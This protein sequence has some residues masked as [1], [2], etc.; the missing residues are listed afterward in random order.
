MVKT[1]TGLKVNKVTEL[2]RLAKKRVSFDERN[3]KINYQA[4]A[5]LLN[6]R[7]S[8]NKIVNSR[9]DDNGVIHSWDKN[10]NLVNLEIL[11]LYGI[12]ETV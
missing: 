12:F 9:M 7:F 6:I 11:D 2:L 8:E 1:R 5:D 10:E 4:D 3:V